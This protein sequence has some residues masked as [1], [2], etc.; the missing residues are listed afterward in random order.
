M[1]FDLRKTRAST[2][3]DEMDQDDIFLYDDKKSNILD[4]L[5]NIEINPKKIISFF[6]RLALCGVGALILIRYE[7]QNIEKL[8]KERTMVTTEFNKLK[9]QKEQIKKEIDGFGYMVKKSKEFDNKLEIM[10]AI[11]DSRL[12]AL[13]GLDH[14]QNIIPEEVWLRRVKFDN[15]R[16]TLTGL[17][18]NNKQIQNFMKALEGTNL[19]SQVNLERSGI[20]ASSKSDTRRHFTILS[21]LKHQEK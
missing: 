15:N 19:F 11:V 18:V 17:S 21:L 9:S 10:Q 13:I 6:F 8:S 20:D 3:V 2:V 4:S 5:S 12:S 7:K 16:F 14:I 1:K